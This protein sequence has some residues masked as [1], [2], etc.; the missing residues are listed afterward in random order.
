M[1]EALSQAPD[2]SLSQAAWQAYLALFAPVYPAPEELP[3]LRA[4]YR[5]QVWSLLEAA[6]WA[7][8]PAA[9]RHL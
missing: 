6:R 2:N 8:H 4:N 9:S 5:G 7:E 1:L 3:A